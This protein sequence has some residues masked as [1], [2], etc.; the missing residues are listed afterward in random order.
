MSINKIT[1]SEYIQR[2]K[3]SLF[4]PDS[5]TEEALYYTQLAL[6][7]YRYDK[8]KYR[9]NLRIFA[10][11][12]TKNWL[13]PK[14]TLQIL[15]YIDTRFFTRVLT[16]FCFLFV[17][18]KLKIK[19]YPRKD[20][21]TNLRFIIKDVTNKYLSNKKNKKK[22][23]SLLNNLEIVKM[24]DEF[25][26]NFWQNLI[27][28]D[29]IKLNKGGTLHLQEETTKPM[30]DTFLVETFKDYPTL[31][32][33]KDWDLNGDSGGYYV[34][35][36]TFLKQND[37]Y[38]G[39]VFY[40]EKLV[41]LIN[42]IQ[43]TA[44][45][46]DL[47]QK[48]IDM[49][50]KYKPDALV[51]TSE[52]DDIQ[53]QLHIY[54]FLRD[55]M[56]KV[57]TVYYPYQIDFRG[58]IYP[59]PSS[60][61]PVSS[62][63]LRT[64]L[65]TPTCYPLTEESKPWLDLLLSHVLEL[66]KNSYNESLLSLS[67]IPNINDYVSGLEDNYTKYIAQKILCDK[68]DGVSNLLIQKDAT[69]S[70]FQILAVLFNSKE[71]MEDTNVLGKDTTTLTPYSTHSYKD[72]YTKVLD[73][74][75]K[76]TPFEELSLLLK[77]KFV[78]PIT[79]TF[80]YG[81]SEMTG[82]DQIIDYLKDLEDKYKNSKGKN[83]KEF[84][85]FW[86]ISDETLL[87]YASSKMQKKYKN[88][89]L[90]SDRG[91]AWEYRRRLY[92]TIFHRHIIDII[93]KLYPILQDFKAAFIEPSSEY[94]MG[95]FKNPYLEFENKYYRENKYIIYSRPTI[96]KSKTNK[97][98][99]RRIELSFREID[100]N[101]INEGS[102][103]AGANYV[104]SLDAFI[105]YFILENKPKDVPIFTIHDCI[106]MRAID[107]PLILTLVK[108]AMTEI[109]NMA[110]THPFFSQYHKNGSIPIESYNIFKLEYGD[111]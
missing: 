56:S 7:S 101:S 67:K 79:M 84:E 105:L 74:A 12:V 22:A 23:Y 15:D 69:S 18:E 54:F 93:Y 10:A 32:E 36:R 9:E 106:L 75:I 85:I 52:S 5:L 91:K 51:S 111:K 41:S 80:A 50:F 102:L 96:S 59:I 13:Y 63:K 25:L 81:A 97:R 95:V 28:L 31:I 76:S 37:E 20:I 78:K 21:D 98:K 8:E 108:R 16:Y 17:I 57:H 103:A 71:L 64:Y 45:S 62:K 110:K 55:F 43:K 19:N 48:Y 89:L 86:G 27:L 34:N 33:P 82:V 61:S 39:R 100:R 29:Y 104:H 38:A 87:E 2:L 4:L 26:N 46:F 40:N 90:S 49:E 109:Q 60:F 24:H 73:L 107:V 11:N 68:S 53:Q 72:I 30:F 47:P 6:E 14:K 58:R 94:Q 44:W 1:Y 70:V 99:A 42:H 77:R 92:A 83:Y 3:N 88:H 35:S 66:N 65:R